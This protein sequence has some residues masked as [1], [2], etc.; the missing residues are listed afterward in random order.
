MEAKKI[1]I[2]FMSDWATTGFG[3]VGTELCQRLADM[4]VFDVHYLGWVSLPDQ[5]PAAARN[6]ITLHNTNF[7]D[8]NDQFGRVSME[9][10]IDKIKPQVIITLGDPW[11]IDHTALMKQRESFTWLAYVPVDRDV[12]CLPWVNML[13]KPDCLVLYSE[14]GKM[15]VDGQMPFRNARVILHGIDRM[16]FKPWFPEGTNEETDH[17][18]LMS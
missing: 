10:L 8:P 4:E 16:V 15:V 3:T 9:R 17:Q 6:K 5:I 18:E 14:F 2:L 7:W 11:M 1:T 12:I 13:K